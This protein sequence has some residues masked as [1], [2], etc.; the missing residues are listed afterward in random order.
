MVWKDQ[1][2]P[3]KY[4]CKTINSSA[5]PVIFY[6]KPSCIILNADTKY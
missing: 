3:L 5:V 1:T 6:S 4:V 2:N